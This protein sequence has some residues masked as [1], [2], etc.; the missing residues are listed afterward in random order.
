VV[1][2]KTECTEQRLFNKIRELILAGREASSFPMRS[3]T[4]MVADLA[5][6]RFD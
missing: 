3:F 1:P 2:E 5:H 4:V 6:I